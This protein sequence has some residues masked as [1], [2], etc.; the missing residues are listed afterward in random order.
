MDYLTFHIREEAT[1]AIKTFLR[2]MG[3]AADAQPTYTFAP[4]EG[5]CELTVGTAGGAALPL[6]L[7][8]CV[9]V[10]EDPLAL[11]KATRWRTPQYHGARPPADTD[12]GVKEIAFWIDGAVMARLFE[13]G[14]SAAGLYDFD[15]RFRP[16]ED[17]VTVWAKERSGGDAVELSAGLD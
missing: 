16:Y 4:A 6:T 5:G 1:E 12:I 11:D 14:W 2:E 15:Y 13:M 7:G 17:G 10:E 8:H 3:S 9:H